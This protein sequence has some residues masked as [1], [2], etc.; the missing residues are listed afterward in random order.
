MDVIGLIKA[1]Y[2]K[3]GMSD[4]EALAKARIV[5]EQLLKDAFLYDDDLIHTIR[6]E[7]HAQL[8]YYRG[9]KEQLEKRHIINRDINQIPLSDKHRMMSRA[10][11]R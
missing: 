8:N 11:V 5:G 1:Q 3:N 9:A 7:Y 10:A 4:N 2:T 6:D